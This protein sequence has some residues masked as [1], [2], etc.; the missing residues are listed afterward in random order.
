M[1]FIRIAT[2]TTAL[3]LV[4]GS[5]W[6]ADT[7]YIRVDVGQTYGSLYNGIETWAQVRVFNNS[8]S[9]RTSHH[10]DTLHHVT[11]SGYDGSCCHAD[12]YARYGSSDTGI[13]ANSHSFTAS[14]GLCY[15]TE[16]EGVDRA[17]DRQGRGTAK[18]C[19]APLAPPPPNCKEPAADGTCPPTGSTCTE[20]TPPEECQYSPIIINNGRGGYRLA[21]ATDPVIFDID[22]DGAKERITWTAR[23]EPMAFLALDRDGNGRIDGG[24][25][26]F[27]NA[28]LLPT[29]AA[30]ASGFEALRVLDDDQNGRLDA[31]DTAWAT[32]ILWTDADHNGASEPGEIVKL[33]ATDITSLDLDSH[34]SGRKDP[35]GNAYRFKSTLHRGNAA[36]PFYD[37]WFARAS[38]VP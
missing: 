4:A 9:I 1:T 35:S 16:A 31:G 38:V 8:G 28:T 10:I 14:R 33:A 26:L 37:I 36:E 21:D 15:R 11:V 17:G 29:G 27:G 30:A 22:G 24:R 3:L 32:L 20:F 6:T 19:V 23:Q 7:Y 13:W 34:A 2:I 18:D 5:S 25:E 12:A